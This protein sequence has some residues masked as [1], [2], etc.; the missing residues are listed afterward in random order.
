M[1]TLEEETLN[2]CPEKINRNEESC[3]TLGDS[4][5]NSPIREENDSDTCSEEMFELAAQT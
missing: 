4:S 3:E 2:D 1:S 5:N